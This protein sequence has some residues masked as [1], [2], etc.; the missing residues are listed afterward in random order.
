MRFATTNAVSDSNTRWNDTEPTSTVFTL[1][2]EHEGNTNDGNHIAFCFTNIKGYSK[3]GKYTGNGNANGTFV[4]TG[5]KAAWLML[6]RTDTTSDWSIY[7]IKRE[8]FNA[9]DPQYEFDLQI[10]ANDSAAE[11]SD[12]QL[13]IYSNGFK[14]RSTDAFTNASG[15]TYIYMAFA[16][17]PF[18]NSNGVP[19][20]AR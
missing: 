4:H 3:I 2:T 1:G 8:N 7:D 6:K 10:E 14:F 20:N 11:G 13:G 16:E 9:G 18:V 17:T 15:G 12:G 19:T 5:F